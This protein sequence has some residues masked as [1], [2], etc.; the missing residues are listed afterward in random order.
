MF[1]CDS[2]VDIVILFDIKINN[3]YLLCGLTQGS[4]NAKL[5]FNLIVHKLNI[6]AILRIELVI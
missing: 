4:I 6:T 3:Y 5:S 1:V 2:V